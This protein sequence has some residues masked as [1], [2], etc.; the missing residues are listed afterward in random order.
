MA[1]NNG[2]TISHP[3]FD[4]VSRVRYS[5]L[6]RFLD[7]KSTIFGSRLSESHTDL[8]R[9]V[10]RITEWSG[11]AELKLK[12]DKDLVIL[13]D[14]ILALDNPTVNKLYYDYR[15]FV[16]AP[17]IWRLCAAIYRAW[18]EKWYQGANTAEI[19]EKFVFKRPE[20]EAIIN[21][22]YLDAD[23]MVENDYYELKVDS[24][25]K[26][27]LGEVYPL[28]DPDLCAQYYIIYAIMGDNGYDAKTIFKE[29]LCDID[30]LIRASRIEDMYEEGAGKRLEEDI[31]RMVESG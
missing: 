12:S 18:Q 27:L 7:E 13:I 4:P 2:D 23:M 14:G 25:L 15:I 24:D 11:D 28:T 20:E 5:K 6:G 10:N 30:E 29:R 3:V 21:V 1:V 19:I 26:T 16:H 17:W 9:N 31:C 8:F 22:T